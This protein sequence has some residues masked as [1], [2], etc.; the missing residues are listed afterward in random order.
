MKLH[1]LAA[2]GTKGYTTWGCIWEKGACAKEMDYVCRNAA[3]EEVPMQSRITAYW[4]D[5]SVKW[6]AHT[7]DSALLKEAPEVTRVGPGIVGEKEKRRGDTVA[8]RLRSGSEGIRWEETQD[9]I[10]IDN[11]VLTVRIGKNGTTLFDTVW[12]GD[13]VLACGA[14]PVL[15]LEEPSVW[16]GNS[17]KTEKRY[18]GSRISAQLEETGKLQCIVKFMGC[19]ENGAGETKIPFILRMRIN[20]RTRELYFTHTFLYD[21]DENRDF[22]KGLGIR[23]DVPLKGSI[24]NRHIKV[25]GDHGV[26]HESMVSLM[27]WRP[28]I[29]QGIYE[30]QTSGERVTLTGEELATVEKVLE[31]T[32]YW[33]KYDICQDSA[34]HFCIRK[35]LRPEECCYID[36]LHG[37]RTDG[38]VAIGS[39]SGS[40]LMSIRDFWEKYPSGYTVESMDTD[41]AGCTLWFWSPSA[42]PMDFR[43]YATR[44]Y[45]QVCYEGYDYKGA[46]PVGIACTNECAIGFRDDLIPT[47]QELTEFT[48]SVKHPVQYV[49]TPEYYH[50]RR[51]FGYWSLPSSGTKTERWLEKQ[52]EEAFVFYR[53]EVEQRGWYGMF[54]Y[55]DFMHTYDKAR[56]QWRYDIGGYAW[57]NTALV[58]TLWLWLYFMRTGRADVFELAARLSRHAS[59]VDVYHMG[60]YKGLGSRHNVR[61]W[62]CPCKEAR[63]AMA[64]HHRFYYYLTGD[65]RLEDIF[66]ELKDNELSFLNRDPLGDFYDK[67]EMVYP[68]HARSGPDWSSLCSNWMTRWERFDDDAYRRKI[69]IGIADIKNAPLKLV[70]GPDFEFDPES[71]HLRY[72]GECTT[73]GTHLQICMGAPQIWM[74][75][76]DLLEDEEW[77]S[78]LAEYGR[79]YYLPREEQLAESGGLIGER[80]FTLP[81]MSAAMGA[82][83]AAYRKDRVLAE[84]TWRTLLE[85]LIFERDL[86]GFAHD[87]L[88]DCGNCKVLREIP[89]I[90]TNFAAQFCLNV[91]MA[92]EFIRES[93]PA[94][95]EGAEEL[96]AGADEMY[97]RK[98]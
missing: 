96:V 20:Y 53:D 61:H 80:E 81:F 15:L 63:I 45:N 8:E 79:F 5:G 50:E 74:E 16:N 47:D 32:P 4:P 51:A 83:G 40:V 26:F 39:E 84:R 58:P 73:G 19:H 55:G 86:N 43:H 91:I 29:P 62:G 37:S 94:T 33:S 22:L 9:G 48:E 78:M 95:L 49:G 59:E 97:F 82:Y 76:G 25:M 21:G 66:E 70:S 90:S 36:S 7:A 41:I 46:D 44:G 89:W 2:G 67:K 85:T 27:S 68:S 54:N 88:A 1:R 87:E 60:R 56:H 64:A 12:E 11:G 71:C 30:R 98:A 69:E 72:I 35:K 28:R 6:T 14:R 3:G 34:Q 42:Q 75:V 17:V 65:R 24:Y 13:R 77:K 52:L 93:L 23:F 31:D 57:D 18:E 92:L 38:G 10:A